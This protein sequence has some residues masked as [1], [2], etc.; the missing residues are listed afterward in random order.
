MTLLEKCITTLGNAT[1]TLSQEETTTIFDKMTNQ[2]SIT[3]WGR[4]DWGK[5]R[6]KK[7][8]S[9]DQVAKDVS[10]S[11]EVFIL[12]DEGSLPALKTTVKNVLQ[13]IDDVTAVSF[14]TWIYSSKGDYI[15]EFYHENEI[16]IGWSNT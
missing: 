16:K 14:D 11:D 4:I 1:S 3:S 7:V 9:L 10:A 2:F 6:H 8:S 15:I 12:W 13:A 5:V